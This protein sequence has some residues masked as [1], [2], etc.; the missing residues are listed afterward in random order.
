MKRFVMLLT[1][2]LLVCFASCKFEPKVV[3]TGLRVDDSS[4]KKSYYV[5][6]NLD[7]SNLK[8]YAQ[9]SDGSE[10][11]I[12]NYV[13]SKT[14]GM[15]LE[16]AETLDVDVI[17][18]SFTAKFSISIADVYLERIELDTENVKVNYKHGDSLDL[19]GLIVTGF[20]NDGSKKVLTEYDASIT[21]G[22][23]LKK[24]G[25]NSVVISY[26]DCTSS[27]DINVDYDS[28]VESVNITIKSYND[29]QNLLTKSEN[30]FIAAEGYKDYIWML[31]DTIVQENSNS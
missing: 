13:T 7:L 2:L 30:T 26:E 21:N 16:T 20:Y 22:T 19:S 31:D 28:T 8:V 4:V 23:T 12:N 29:V 24:A 5:G 18:E 17:Y 3:L 9:Y 6:D 1:S 25:V 14:D 10:K 27:F 15:L 11:E